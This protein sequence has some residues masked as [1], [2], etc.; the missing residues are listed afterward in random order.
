MTTVL[1]FDAG[2]FDADAADADRP[3]VMPGGPVERLM[4]SPARM[5]PRLRRWLAWLQLSTTPAWVPD[6]LIGLPA[7][8]AKAAAEVAWAGA[9]R[10]WPASVPSPSSTGGVGALVLD[11]DGADPL[12]EL[13]GRVGV[14][15][16]V[17]ELDRGDMVH[18][19]LWPREAGPRIYVPFDADGPAYVGQTSRRLAHRVPEHFGRRA[20]ADERRKATTWTGVA[21]A[22]FTDLRH[23]DL[24]RLERLAADWILPL[25]HRTGRHFPKNG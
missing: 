12:L 17:L 25:R 2:W 1:E 24:G 11:P 16:M 15:W 7:G 4:P 18:P 20:S 19:E 8:P 6:T 23:G 14:P 21:S 13:I 3:A 10:S 9:D 22:R 5:D